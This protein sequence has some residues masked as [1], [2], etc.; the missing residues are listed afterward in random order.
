MHS[1]PSS[2]KS[3]LK[4]FADFQKEKKVLKQQERNLIK[5]N[6]NATTTL[7]NPNNTSEQLHA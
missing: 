5:L 4:G 6:S 1:V 7:Y 3:I 2:K